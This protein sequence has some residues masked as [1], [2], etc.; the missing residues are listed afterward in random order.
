MPCGDKD[1]KE[2]SKIKRREG[3][4]VGALRAGRA[5]QS[6]LRHGWAA[7]A[8]LVCAGSCL[9]AQRQKGEQQQEH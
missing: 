2:R 3:S 5:A 9:K 7:T 4:E 1:Y 8:S 6:S